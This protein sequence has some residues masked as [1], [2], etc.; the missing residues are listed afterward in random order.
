MLHYC[1]LIDT[2]V[3]NVEPEFEEVIEECDEVFVN[4]ASE[5]TDF[6]SDPTL[7]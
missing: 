7:T 5:A 2:A 1:L 4:S 3:T 6:S